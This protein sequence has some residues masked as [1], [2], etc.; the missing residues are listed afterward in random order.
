MAATTSPV[1]R[2]RCSGAACGTMRRWV[3]QR[4]L[5]AAWQSTPRA[6]FSREWGSHIVRRP[7][8]DSVAARP[9]RGGAWRHGRRS[10][11]AEW[12]GGRPPR[13]SSILPSH[14]LPCASSRSVGAA[15]AGIRGHA[16]R[17]RPPAL[18]LD[19]AQRAPRTCFSRRLK[20]ACPAEEYAQ[21]PTALCD[22]RRP[23]RCW[24]IDPAQLPQSGEQLGIDS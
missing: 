6:E 12:A 8:C 3:R 23:G 9:I 5:A 11:V 7:V 24:H 10:C 22:V 13:D 16:V 14:I 19:A 1:I 21:T 2:L 18:D 15:P 20:V 17:C 4:G